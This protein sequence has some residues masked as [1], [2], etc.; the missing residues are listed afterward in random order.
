MHMTRIVFTLFILL[1]TARSCFYVDDSR[2]YVEINQDYVPTVT[3]TS[4]FDTIDSIRIVDSLMFRYE[5]EIDTGRLYYADI[6]LG[7]L[8]LFRS[9]TLA[10]SLWLYPNYINDGE[11]YDV[12]VR[13]FYK[14]FSGS[15]ADV[16]NA[17]FFIT[18]STWAVTFFKELE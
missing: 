4:N 6:Y 9:D 14:K 15:L 5:I 18:D 1:L 3:I 13:A 16:I 7:S 17:E 11:T 2:Y 8:Q 10:D 12:T